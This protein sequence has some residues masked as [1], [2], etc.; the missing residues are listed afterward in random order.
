MNEPPDSQLR[1]RQEL[2]TAYIPLVRKTAYRLVARLP[3]HVEVEELVSIGMLGLINAV[4]RYDPEQAV[5]F[6]L[7]AKIR[8]Q[9]AI[10]DALREQDWVP[11][12]VRDLGH[13]LNDVRA[14]LRVALD[15][16][17][18]DAEMAQAMGMPV[19]A[20]QEVEARV[21]PRVVLS[22]EEKQDD[23]SAVMDTLPSAMP[24]PDEVA[25][26]ESTRREVRKLLQALP[27]RE[28][29]IVDLYYERNM[30]LKEIGVVLG[31][32]EGR[33][34][35]LHARIL[36]TLETRLRNKRDEV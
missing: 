29:V 32:S 33:V 16:E 31:V 1:S 18:N 12:S 17:P 8:V 6:P 25:L 34:S 22:T 4:D 2:I 15:R 28:K 24:G 13:R 10:L 9:G 11:R 7:F 36:E 27:Q 23:G 21:A 19:E 3:R 5:S 20:L 26:R 14:Q 35:R 30:T